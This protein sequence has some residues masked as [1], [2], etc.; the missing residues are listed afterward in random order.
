VI[1]WI[2]VD[3]DKVSI[4]GGKAILAAIMSTGAS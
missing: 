1:S 4:A 3:D 2:E